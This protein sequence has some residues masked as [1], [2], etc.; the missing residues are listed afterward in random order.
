MSVYPTFKRGM[1]FSELDARELQNLIRAAVRSER[2]STGGGLE[3]LNT[4]SGL[5]VWGGNNP[6]HRPRRFFKVAVRDTSGN[7]IKVREVRYR[8]A[9]PVEGEYGWFGDEFE[10]WPDFG[11]TIADYEPFEI[12][13]ESPPGDGVYLRAVRLNEAWIVEFPATGGGAELARFQ[14]VEHLP[15]TLRCKRIGDDGQPVAEDTTVAKTPILRKSY[16]DQKPFRYE[17]VVAQIW[18]TNIAPHYRFAWQNNIGNSVNQQ[19]IIIP[20]FWI[21]EPLLCEKVGEKITGITGVDWLMRNDEGRA[22][23]ALRQ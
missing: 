8:E 5:R 13:D 19:E 23:A 17:G 4:P 15:E 10:A 16:Y 6:E 18:Y 3:S 22:W 12:T 20:A 14:L 21:G 2:V 7:A 11:K 9:V 1:R